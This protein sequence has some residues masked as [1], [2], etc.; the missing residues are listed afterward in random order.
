M[1]CHKGLVHAAQ[2]VFSFF[3]DFLVANFQQGS[4]NG[5]HFGA[6][7]TKMEVCIW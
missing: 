3:F 4:L 6:G 1:E 5:T 2:V 7:S